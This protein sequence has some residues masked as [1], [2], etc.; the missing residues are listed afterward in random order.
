[1]EGGIL[2][3]IM[4]G[5]Y[6][7]KSFELGLISVREAS[8]KFLNI[9]RKRKGFF[10]RCRKRRRT[11]GNEMKC[12]EEEKEGGKKK[13]EMLMKRTKSEARSS[14]AIYIYIYI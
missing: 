6:A 13:V 9:I 5:T 12:E 14:R 8:K 11:K 3:A 2:S 10:K 1:M 7:V 4:Y